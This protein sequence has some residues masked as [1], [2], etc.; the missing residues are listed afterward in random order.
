MIPIGNRPDSDS[1]NPLIRALCDPRRYPHA[2]DSVQVLET[3]IS[4][5]LLT[6]RYAYK[7]K[8]PVNLGF[9]DFSTLEQRRFYCQEELRLN[10]RLAPQLYLDVIA[11]GGTPEN[12]CLGSSLSAIEY[13]LQ[14]IQFPQSDRLDRVLARGGLSAPICDSLARAVAHFH[15]ETTVAPADSPFG[16]Y[17]RVHEPV[18]ESFRQIVSR[19]GE[20]EQTSRLG[21]WCRDEHVRRRP[22]FTRRQEQGFIRECHGDLHLENMVLLDGLVTLFDCIEFSDHLRWIDVI[23]DLA[24]ALMDLRH[25]GRPELAGRL[26]NAYLELTGDYEG[27]KVLRYYLVYRALV[28]ASVSCIRESQANLSDE[29]RSTNRQRCEQY[30]ELA[31]R[32][33]QPPSPWLAVAHGVSGS[34]KTSYTQSLL[35]AAVA[36]RIRSDVERKRLS[37]MLPTARATDSIAEALYS[38]EMTRAA[39]DRLDALAQSILDAGYPVIVDAANLKRAQRQRFCAIAA[40]KRVPYVILDFQA[41]ESVLRARIERRTLTGHDASDAT[42]GVLEEQLRTQEPLTAEE[43]A[44][45]VLINAESPLPIAT[46][47]ERLRQ[48]AAG[49]ASGLP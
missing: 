16:S 32:D 42:L 10:R 7:F 19:E 1:T 48:L 15:Q 29:D 39:Y 13:A 24:F 41:P 36:I 20:S 8:K 37:G 4:W 2:V 35:E 33:M 23:S 22:D 40:S 21:G 25:R 27:T 47:A 3:H 11:I 12:P 43:R 31:C 46:L 34:G 9:L 45:S 14:M 17:D 44:A 18:E 5:V 26:L 38:P 30:L 49:T 6:G 28:R